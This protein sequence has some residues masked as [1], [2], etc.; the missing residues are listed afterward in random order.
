MDSSSYQRAML[1][2]FHRSDDATGR[3]TLRLLRGFE[4]LGHAEVGLQVILPVQAIGGKFIE[5]FGQGGED[6]TVSPG[7]GGEFPLP[8]HLGLLYSGMAGLERMSGALPR[9]SVQS[10]LSVGV[11][12]RS[13]LGA[14][15]EG[16]TVSNC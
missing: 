2:K 15:L 16:L 5:H 6:P 3:V 10:V 8:A 14:W 9:L 7:A 12:L 4:F 11:F 1:T 13:V